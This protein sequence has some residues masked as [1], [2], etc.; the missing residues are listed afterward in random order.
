[1][2]RKQIIQR[3]ENF[4]KVGIEVFLEKEDDYFVSYCPALE[5]SSYGNTEEEARKNF[6]TELEIF[7][8]ET[9]KRGTLEKILLKLGWCLT[10]NPKPAYTPPE[11]H[12]YSQLL[13]QR[14]TFRETISLPL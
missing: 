14:Q 8:E 12:K 6:E 5:L 13:N 1:M 10:H 4:I 2:M 11:A 9:E 7:L 3:T